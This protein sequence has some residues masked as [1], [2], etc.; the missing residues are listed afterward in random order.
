[1]INFNNKVLFSKIYKIINIFIIINLFIKEIKIFN[2]IK[3]TNFINKI[4]ITKTIISKVNNINYSKIINF[5]N[6]FIF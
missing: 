6:I 3:T 4:K 5:C 2:N 1:M